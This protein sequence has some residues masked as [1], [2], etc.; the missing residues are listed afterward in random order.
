MCIGPFFSIVEKG[1]PMNRI[2]KTVWNVAR[3]ALVVVNEKTGI[4]QS[5]CA[6][7]GGGF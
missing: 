3:K 1:D 6:A 7:R 5:R 2:F 4:G